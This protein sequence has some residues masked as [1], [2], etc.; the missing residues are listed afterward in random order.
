MIHR[1]ECDGGCTCD[2]PAH[3]QES[4]LAGCQEA[5]R[6]EDL[7]ELRST[8]GEARMGIVGKYIPTWLEEGIGGTLTDTAGAKKVGPCK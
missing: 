3:M 4:L 5:K 1:Y 7:R 2:I 6:P 8:L